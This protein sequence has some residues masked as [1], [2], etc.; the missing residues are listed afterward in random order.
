MA[1]SSGSI[2]EKLD[3]DLDFSEF[4]GSNPI[5]Q[6]FVSSHLQPT[7]WID[8]NCLGRRNWLRGKVLLIIANKGSRL[9]ILRWPFHPV[10]HTHN[11]NPR[12]SLVKGSFRFGVAII[13]D[14]QDYC[15]FLSI[16]LKLI[17]KTA[18]TPML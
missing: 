14:E 18:M 7:T 12:D 10:G 15:G 17:A 16:I 13:S 4:C 8:S 5:F 1:Q 11:L 6:R 9:D 2:L 3:L